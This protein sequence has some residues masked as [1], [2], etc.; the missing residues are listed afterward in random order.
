LAPADFVGGEFLKT[1][2]SSGVAEATRPVDI[3]L[4][5][6]VNLFDTADVYSKGLP[7]SILGRAVAGRRDRVLISPKTTFR[8][9]P[10]PNDLV[11]SHHH[12]IQT[13]EA[14]LK[15]LGTDHIDI[16]HLHGGHSQ[17]V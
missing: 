5:P 1:G 9:G 8:M 10:G 11:S 12:L 2:G 3:C 6:G 14:N 15:R 17:L 7:E 16:D 13:C 4:D